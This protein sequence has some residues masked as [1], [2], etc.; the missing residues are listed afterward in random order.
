[1]LTANIVDE[2]AS[3]LESRS[4]T[5][6]NPTIMNKHVRRK[7]KLIHAFIVYSPPTSTGDEQEQ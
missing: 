5:W 2:C 4:H 6:N 3:V 7:R 1:M